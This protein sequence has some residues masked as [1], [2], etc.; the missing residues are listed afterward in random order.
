MKKLE[1][2]VFHCTATPG[3]KFLPPENLR[4]IHCGPP[5]AGRGWKQVGY[6]RLIQPDGRV[7]ILVPNDGDDYV[8]PEEITNGAMGY[9]AFSY[10]VAY[11]GGLDRRLKPADT[12]TQMQEWVMEDVVR[13]MIF[14]HP[15]IKVAGHNQLTDKKACPCFDV[16]DWLLEI[17]IPEKN[18]YG[19]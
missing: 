1:L 15:D 13:E 16:Q 3:D 17:G 10:H 4:R 19:L 8:D 18:I 6:S 7:D 5:P 9:N 11:A 12:R 2:L 14:K